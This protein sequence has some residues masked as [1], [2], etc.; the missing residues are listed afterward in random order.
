MPEVK[1]AADRSALS[2]VASAPGGRNGPAS[3]GVR[4]AWLIPLPGLAEVHQEM[5]AGRP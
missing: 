2:E 1:V 5:R 3:D 4:L